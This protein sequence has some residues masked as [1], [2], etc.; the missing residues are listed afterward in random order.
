MFDSFCKVLCLVAMEKPVSLKPEHIRDE[1]VK[2][3]K[4][5]YTLDVQYTY[6]KR[7][8]CLSALASTP[9]VYVFFVQALS[10]PLKE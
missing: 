10:T 5:I 4:S 8:D 7:H 1:K 9:T 3:L 6:T 2:V